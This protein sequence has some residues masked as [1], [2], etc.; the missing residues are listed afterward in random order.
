MQM[1]EEKG[2]RAG[3]FV[4]PVLLQFDPL[5]KIKSPV[6]HCGCLAHSYFFLHCAIMYILRET[7]TSVSIGFLTILDKFIFTIQIRP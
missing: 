3:P 4:Y 6:T 7:Q 1:A 2:V 5:P